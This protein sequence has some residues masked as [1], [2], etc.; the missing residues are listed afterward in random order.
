MS[1]AVMPSSRPDAV[2][3]CVGTF[4][5]PGDD[6]SPLRAALVVTPFEGINQFGPGNVLDVLEW[7]EFHQRSLL[8]GVRSNI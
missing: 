1:P 3:V 8:C 2:V 6:D 7:L 4:V 5:G